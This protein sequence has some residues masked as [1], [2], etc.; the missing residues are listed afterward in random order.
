MH[1]DGEQV[2]RWD[3]RGYD[4]RFGVISAYGAGV[5]E[6]LAAQPGERVLDLGCGTGHQAAAL[7]EAGAQVVGVDRDEQMLEV[8]R[9]AHPEVRFVQG[10]A[11][12]LD[13]AALR[14]LVGGP[15]DAVVSNAALHWMPQ[16]DDVVAGVAGLLRPGGRFVAEM[17]GVGNVA[18]LAAAIRTAREAVG[19]GPDVTVPWTFPT[20]GE[21]ATRLERH[22][23]VVGMLVR[24]ERLTPLA[25][26]DTAA[27]WA[28][29]F[30]GSLV[31]DVPPEHRADFDDAVDV[32]ARAAGLADRP[33]GDEGWWGDYVRLRFSAH[34]P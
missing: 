26:G 18:R 29:M 22:G 7:A 6:L 27:S 4:D 25:P 9:A 19:L 32:A 2:K 31:A 12:R 17:G 15:Y 8:A 5:L 30:G 21:L 1:Q 33:D 23:F 24:F 16:Q 28:Q 20:A 3:A 10:D 13:T 14:D 34:L 11:Q